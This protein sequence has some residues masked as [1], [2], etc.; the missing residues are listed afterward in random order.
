MTADVEDYFD[1]LLEPIDGLENVLKE[2]PSDSPLKQPRLLFVRFREHEPQLNEF[3]ELLS[4]HLVDYAIPLA[5]RQHA[6]AQGANSR[7]GGSMTAASRLRRE[8]IRLLVKYSKENSS[9]YGEIGELISYVVAVHFLRAGQIG[10]KMALKTSSEM[11][12]HGADGLHARANPDGTVTFFLLESKLTPSAADASR[13]MVE[14]LSEFQADRSRQLNELRLVNDLSNLEALQGEQR[15]AAKSFFNVYSG[16]GNHLKRRDI[17]VGSLVYSEPSYNE[18]LPRDAEQPITIHE[19]N[20]EYK[21]SAKHPRFQKNLTNQ[22]KAKEFDLGGCIVFLI[23]VPDVYELKR[24][25][26]E[27]NNEHICE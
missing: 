18:K 23:A 21:Y 16:N 5:K 2:V 12:I 20:F 24:I 4:D 26:A 22:A 3:V 9:R 14:S 10:A 25:F 27:L 19:E 17:H 6:N 8:A 15:E 1:V 13:E 7:T 11:P